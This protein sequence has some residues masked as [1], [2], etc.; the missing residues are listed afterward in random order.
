MEDLSLVLALEDTHLQQSAFSQVRSGG[1]M[2]GVTTLDH[3]LYCH[4]VDSTYN[5]I[6]VH[7][8]VHERG[9]KKNGYNYNFGTMRLDPVHFTYPYCPSI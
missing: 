3:D 8:L 5:N 9:V 4:F 7:G 1:Y 6:I 2:Q